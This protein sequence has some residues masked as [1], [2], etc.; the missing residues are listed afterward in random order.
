[1]Y[2]L[3][4]FVYLFGVVVGGV[5]FSIFVSLV[6][7]VVVVFLF[8]FYCGFCTRSREGGERGP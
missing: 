2:H 5:F 7:V 6:F 8:L 4:C 3:I 1:M